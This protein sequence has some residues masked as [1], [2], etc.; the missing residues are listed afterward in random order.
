MVLE[1]GKMSFRDS[2]RLGDDHIEPT[3]NLKLIEAV[4]HSRC[5]YDSTDRQYRSSEYKNRVGSASKSFL[6]PI[7]RFGIV[8]YRSWALKA[9]PGP[10]M[11]GGNSSETSGPLIN[12]NLLFR[13][14]K[15]K[16]KAKYNNDQSSWQYYKHL[17][18][19]DPHMIDRTQQQS[20]S[21]KESV[22]MVGQPLPF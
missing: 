22:D 13:Y 4:K 9:T 18:F 12:E 7:F 8:L 16:R 10:C 11:P 19:L 20:P 3:F 21:R 2:Y 15:E 17:H 14:G 1:K 5:L 6:F